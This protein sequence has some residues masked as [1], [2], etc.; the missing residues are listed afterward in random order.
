[1]LRIVSV[2]LQITSIPMDAFRSPYI[3]SN[4]DRAITEKNLFLSSKTK[5]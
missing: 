5:N 3:G 4:N 2:S 1:M